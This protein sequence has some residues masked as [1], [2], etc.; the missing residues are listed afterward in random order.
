MGTTPLDTLIAHKAISLCE[1]LSASEMRVAAAI[2][3]HF[4]RD[5]GQCDPSLESIARLIGVSRR[6]VI[7]AV[8]ALEKKGYICRRR[9]GGNFHRNQYEP[10]WNRFQAM[11]ARWRARRSPA[12]KSGAPDLSLSQRRSCRVAGDMGV[13]QTCPRNSTKETLPMQQPARESCTAES[14]APTVGLSKERNREESYLTANKRFH[15]KTANSRDA[16]RDAAERR[17]NV[18]LTKQIVAAPAVFGS[19]VDAIDIQL[20]NATTDAELRKPGSGIHFLLRELDRRSPVG[21]EKQAANG[22][23][24]PSGEVGAEG[25]SDRE[26]SP[27]SSGFE[28]LNSTKHQPKHGA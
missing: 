28:S 15:V 3:D 23:A 24:V 10:D 14:V 8:S 4:N 18:L 20:S 22:S 21:A 27:A 26:G 16:A 13:T 17:W 19:L 25:N 7:R 6:T 9:H 12:K 11:E 1:D 2:V 5:T